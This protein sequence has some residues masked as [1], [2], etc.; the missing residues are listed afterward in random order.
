MADFRPFSPCWGDISFTEAPRTTAR[1]YAGA[2]FLSRSPFG[3]TARAR[4]VAWPRCPRVAGPGQT[5]RRRTKPHASTPGPTGMEGAGGTGGPGCGARGWRCLA[6]QRGDAP[7]HTPAH[8]APLAWRAP[9]GWR[10]RLRCPWAVAGPGRASGQRASPTPAH[11]APQV[12]RA[13][14]GPEGLAAVPVGGCRAWPDFEAT[15][16]AKLAARTA[17]GR[18]GPPAPRTPAAQHAT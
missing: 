10:A 3:A 14:E 2:I 15:R 7:N 4:G 6:G 12:W 13:P 11:Q 8:Q 17:R 9:E 1:C 16:R 18:P 5:T